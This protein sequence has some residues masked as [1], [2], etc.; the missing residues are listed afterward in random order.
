[1]KDCDLL[2]NFELLK[3]SDLLKD[4]LL[5]DLLKDPHLLTLKDSYLP[6]DS[7]LLKDLKLLKDPLP[8]E[9][10]DQ[11]KNTDLMK[12]LDR[13]ENSDLLKDSDLL[14]DVSCMGTKISWISCLQGKSLLLSPSLDPSSWKVLLLLWRAE[15]GSAGVLNNTEMSVSLSKTKSWVDCIRRWKSWF[16]SGYT[17]LW[18][19]LLV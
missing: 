16:W 9:N 19:P 11:L 14:E 4:S 18:G 8:L 2:E 5:C 13:L 15:L 12:N 17:W 10:S 6:M 3:D 7:D 1:M